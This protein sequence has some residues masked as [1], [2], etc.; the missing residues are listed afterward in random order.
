MGDCACNERMVAEM[1][2]LSAH[3]MVALEV[4]DNIE[5]VA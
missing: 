3:G 1:M 5:D 4:E 2:G